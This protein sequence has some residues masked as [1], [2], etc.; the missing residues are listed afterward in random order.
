MTV[1]QDYVKARQTR[2]LVSHQPLTRFAS[3]RA[4]IIHYSLLANA[5][6]TQQIYGVTAIKVGV[7][8][9]GRRMTVDAAGLRVV[10]E[11][12]PQKI[13]RRVWHIGWGGS[14]HC[15]MLRIFNKLP[16]RSITLPFI[17]A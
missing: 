11:P 9:L 3:G 7:S 12:D 2:F 15:G 14:V 5:I 16:T 17:G 13:E 6:C 10:A 1:R 8:L 4:V